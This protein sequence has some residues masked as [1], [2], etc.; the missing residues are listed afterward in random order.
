MKDQGHTGNLYSTAGSTLDQIVTSTQIGYT[1]GNPKQEDCYRFDCRVK[2]S[3]KNSFG[4]GLRYRYLFV[5][6]VQVY[7]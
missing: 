4:P 6:W 7:F 2:N 5:D 3:H 1:L